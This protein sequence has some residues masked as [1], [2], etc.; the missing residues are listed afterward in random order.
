MSTANPLCLDELHR[1]LTDTQLSALPNSAIQLLEISQDSNNGI[2]EFAQPIEG[3]PGLASQVL[4]FVNSSYFGFS[5]TISSVKMAINL[6]GMRA[7]KN[8]ALWN[9]VFSL[10][11]NPKSSVFHLST[12]W[13]DS[14]RRALFARRM[15]KLL[16][17][18]DAEEVFAGALLQDMVIPMLAETL[19]KEYTEMLEV[20]RDTGQRLSDLER[21][22][23]GWDHGIAAGITGRSW[24]LPE[25]LVHLIEY[26]IDLSNDIHKPLETHERAIAF[27]AL[28]PTVA[29]TLWPE[30]ETFRTHYNLYVPEGSPTIRE[31]FQEIDEEFI[32]FAPM[33]R[34]GTP[35]VTLAMH[36]DQA[37]I[38]FNA[39]A[40][41]N[42]ESAD[43][44]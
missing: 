14:L 18:K 23:F 41:E 11:P 8:F 5:Q 6:V 39:A 15:G 32:E 25:D 42:D 3:D 12:L 40:S 2:V 13:Q 19:P 43:Q 4:R 33:I 29:N 1:I 10:M 31:V 20:V 24:N 35:S 30:F 9:A 17:L 26:H 22:R 28:L 7:I 37:E 27:S 16:G 44:S 34:I 38:A 21:A 36:Y